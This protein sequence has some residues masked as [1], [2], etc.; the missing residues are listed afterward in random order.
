MRACSVL[1]VCAILVFCCGCSF[2]RDLVATNQ[3]SITTDPGA[4]VMIVG[5]QVIANGDEVRISGAVIR[6]PG[7]ETAMAGYVEIAAVDQNGTVTDTVQAS[8]NPRRIPTTGDRQS[9][10]DFMALGVPPKGT[11]LRASFVDEL[12]PTI[13]YLSGLGN[14]HGGGA[15]E[16]HG[17]GGGGGGGTHLSSAA[18]GKHVNTSP[19]GSSGG[20]HFGGG[21]GH[22]GGKK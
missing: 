14:E 17:G 10:F 16:A 11:T 9:T 2:N 6:K 8:L 18:P 7:N 4:N 12:H 19:K 13:D 15:A 5:P 22:G 21:G 1:S 3:V 20:F